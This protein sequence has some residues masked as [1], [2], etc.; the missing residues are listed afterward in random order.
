MTAKKFDPR[1]AAITRK[2]VERG[3]VPRPTNDGPTPSI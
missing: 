3:L 2:A 1:P